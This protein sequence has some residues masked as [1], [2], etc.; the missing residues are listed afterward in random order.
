MCNAYFN[1][2]L[3]SK[4]V[5]GTSILTSFHKDMSQGSVKLSRPG[6]LGAVV[7]LLGDC[8]ACFTVL[9]LALSSDI[10]QLL[11]RAVGHLISRF[12]SNSNLRHRSG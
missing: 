6:P 1:D 4:Y 11:L 9:C 5:K 12:E 7:P 8:H 10:I 3:D 2:T